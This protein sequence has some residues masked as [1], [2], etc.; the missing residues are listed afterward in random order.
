M[1][2]LTILFSMFANH[3]IIHQATHNVDC[4]PGVCRWPVHLPQG[5]V[6]V[7][8][9][10]HT[11]FISLHCEYFHSVLITTTSVFGPLFGPTPLY[12]MIKCPE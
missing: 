12:T 8:V 11:H 9:G 5:F 2:C 1:S 6:R 3:Q 4:Q 7:C 10:E